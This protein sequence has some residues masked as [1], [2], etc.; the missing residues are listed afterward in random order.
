[1]AVL[2]TDIL[3][4]GVRREAAFDWLGDPTNHLRILQNA[5][6]GV[7]DNRD[8]DFSLR[9]AAPAFRRRT[10]GYRFL[11]KD[12]SH[13]GRRVLVETTGKRTAGNL[14]Y[15]LRTMK[16]STNTMVT[17]HMDYT[18][19]DLLGQLIDAVTLRDALEERWKIVL[20]DLKAAIE[21]D[22]I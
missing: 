19:G 15:S 7:H 3:L 2:T 18:P 9:F 12:D 21:A 20:R 17:L 11:K 10:M 8:G 5:F 6:D 16:P 4:T 14:N 1:M 22:Q 13:G